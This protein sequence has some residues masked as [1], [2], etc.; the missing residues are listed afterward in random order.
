LINF[1]GNSDAHIG[2]NGRPNLCF[3]VINTLLKRSFG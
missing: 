2:A 3:D 1:T